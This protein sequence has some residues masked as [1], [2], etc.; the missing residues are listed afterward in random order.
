MK[1]SKV[2][3]F[4]SACLLLCLPLTATAQDDLHIIHGDCLPTN[5]DAATDWAAPGAPRRLPAINTDWDASRTYKQLVILVAPADR[6]FLQEDAQA[7]YNRL[8]NESGYTE[9][10]G[11]GCAADYF[12]DQS[13][14]LL[15]LQFDVYG[16]YKVSTVAC[17]NPS[18]KYYGTDAMKEATNMML[19]E[20]TDMDFS[21]YDWNDNGSVNQVIYVFAGYGG[22]ISGQGG[23]VW[24]NTSSFATITTADGKKISNYTCSAELWTREIYC[25]IGT[26]CHEFSHSLGLP[27]IY[28]VGSA[29]LP[30]STVDEWDLMD[31]GNFT[32]YGWCP[33]N[34]TPLEKMLLGWLTPVELTE[35]ASINNLKPVAEGGE[36][37]KIGHTDSEYLLLENRQWSGWDAGLPGKG[38]VIYHVDYAAGNWS[39][40][41][42]N[43]EA[44][45]PRFSLV[46]ADNLDYDGWV[47]R[48]D[49]MGYSNYQNSNHMNKYHLSTSSY[50]WSTDSTDFVN[51][52][53]TDTSV[54]A[55]VMYH[56]NALGSTELGKPITNIKMTDD[57][58]ISFDFMGG[59][60]GLHSLPSTL[61][62]SPSTSIYDLQGRQVT[63]PVRGELY[64]MKRADG[65][66]SKLRYTDTR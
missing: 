13:G 10:A 19:A 17:P 32:N 64:I 5:A 8:F 3:R 45:K 58:L 56:E 57:G 12:R 38:L 47:A 14:R 29:S 44:G 30:Y 41:S 23:Y 36:V 65:T 4:V 26:I 15:N 34:Y 60:T 33:P 35:A 43:S 49:E 52:E 20:Q 24:P 21:P 11:V 55:A 50:P 1:T 39:G 28:P 48:K 42:V 18:S 22:N 27:D 66:V 25:G 51:R 61:H 37:Y 9:R 6:D 31:G 7:Y 53:L 63:S 16:P 59:T 62:P 40:N 2:C 46:H 54:P